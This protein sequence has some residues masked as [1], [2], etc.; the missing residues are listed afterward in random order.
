ML[1]TASDFKSKNTVKLA[2]FL[3]GKFLVRKIKGKIIRAKIIEVEAY[4]GFLDKASH[5]YKGKT[6]RNFVM[7]GESFVW[8]VYLVYGMHNM[9]NLVTGPKDYPA[10]IL[11]RGIEVK[12]KKINGPGK[13]T[14]FLEIEREFNNLEASKKNNLWLEDLGFKAQNILKTPRIGVDY[15]KE[16]KDE[17]YRFV[18]E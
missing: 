12:G 15:A 13:I 17:L 16:S 1:L 2:K 10:A 3:L 18:L 8:Y 4:D 5:A 14:K 9:L 7:F 6:N 11:I